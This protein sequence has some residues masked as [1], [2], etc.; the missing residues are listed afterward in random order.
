MPGGDAGS[1]GVLDASVAV[2]VV[3]P[4]T[5]TH[6][7]LEVLG[8]SVR[9]IAPR[10]MIVEVA[11][12][13]R[14]KVHGGQLSSLDAA[15]ALAVTLDAVDDGVIALADDEKLAQA[16]LNLALSMDHKVP[17]CL[18]VALAEREGAFLAS[19]DRRLLSLARRRG[20]DVSEVP[21]A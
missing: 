7:S 14:R 20:I 12:A 10:L 18:Y 13:L 17:D 3:V 1:I 4:E 15:S 19:A 9:W 11:S 6:E 21:S 2:K 16:A 5:G 8:R